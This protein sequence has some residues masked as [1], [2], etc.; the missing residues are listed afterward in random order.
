MGAAVPVIQAERMREVYNEETDALSQRAVRTVC[1]AGAPLVLGFAL[2]DYIRYPAIF[3]LSV[4]MRMGTAAVMIATL[5]VLK[6]RFGRGKAPLLAFICV[7]AVGALMC[8]MQAATGAEAS[9]Y[10]AALSILP[11]TVALVMPWHALWTAVMCIGVLAVYGLGTLTTG[12]GMASRAFLDNVST[13]TV[14][15]FIA[16]ATTAMH[17]RQRWREFQLRW[18]LA[19]ADAALRAGE[20]KYQVAVAAAEAANRTK[21]EFLANMSHEIRTPMNGILGMTEL[22]L[23][24]ALTAEQR[25]YLEMVKSSSDSLLTVINDILDF[26]KVEAGKLELDEHD[27]GLRETLNNALKPLCLRA[28]AKGVELASHIPADLPNALFGDAGR[29]RQVLVNLVG[30]AIKFTG[31]GE[32]VVRVSAESQ[33]ANV[34]HLHFAVT[35]TGIGIPAEKLPRIFQPFEQVDSSTTRRYGGTGLGLAISAHLVALMGGRIWVES[36]VGSGSTFHF[37][38]PFGVSSHPQR[39]RHP[40][41]LAQLRNFPVLVVDDNAT[42]RRI[43]YETLC[44]WHMRPTL[45]DGGLAALSELQHAVALSTPF[46]LVLL[47]A[48]M[49]DMDGFALAERIREMPEL[50]GATIMMLASADLLGDAARCRALGIAAYL[51]KPVTQ[52]SLLDAILTVLGSEV[53]VEAAATLLSAV[54]EAQRPLRILLAED[55]IV[56][57]K[58]VVR[59][60]EKRGHVVLVAKNGR[61]ALAAVEQYQFDAVL[62]DLQMPEMD[63][64]EATAAIRARE[65][66]GPRLPIIALTAHAMKGDEE[67]CLEAGMDAYA[68][69]PID[70]KKLF[71]VIE[72]V[73]SIAAPRDAPVC[74]DKDHPA[75]K[76]SDA[77]H[78]DGLLPAVSTPH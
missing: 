17:Q 15:S 18:T 49:P 64:F 13:V 60:L 1:L 62:M 21:S 29:L 66:G 30:N 68:S 34:A 23:N 77:G 10:S 43:L 11:L 70:A 12:E 74:D 46:P 67:R 50:A 42:H 45:V 25:E 75:V 48:C 36:E 71:D 58:L 9:Q 19:E 51:A 72:R 2:F 78:R 32:V 27:F 33:S 63:G 44:H 38:M 76:G 35:D 22:T 26:S 52:S 55:N 5:G 39:E 40:Q 3:H 53:P 47:D 54:Q 16:I 24:T 56:N 57:Q 20:V 73:V 7:T 41:L 14:A 4:V 31:R 28:T 59:L 61:D 6:T 69:K 65:K 37:S 8:A